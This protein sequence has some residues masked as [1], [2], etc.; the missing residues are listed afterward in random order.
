ME[1]DVPS[2]G[3]MTWKLPA[4]FTAHVVWLQLSVLELV[5]EL[6]T[7]NTGGDVNIAAHF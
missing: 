4:G 5:K 3:I 2:V 7:L 1:F 6:N